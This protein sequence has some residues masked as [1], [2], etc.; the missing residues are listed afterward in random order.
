LAGFYV[1]GVENSS[2]VLTEVKIWHC[3][4]LK[5][6]VQTNFFKFENYLTT[7]D[8]VNNCNSDLYLNNYKLST[9]LL[10]LSATRCEAESLFSTI[11]RLRLT[12]EI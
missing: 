12:F 2:K 3:Q 10:I 11:K 9:I 7:I 6:R 1:G 8:V 5:L 4:V